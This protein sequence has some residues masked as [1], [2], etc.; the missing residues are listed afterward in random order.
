MADAI[1]TSGSIPAAPVQYMAKLQF[2]ILPRDLDKWL[3]DRA[4]H[5]GHSKDG[6]IVADL[7]R[8]MLAAT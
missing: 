5:S 8:L 1:T 3:T 2:V 7:R 4:V 6:Q